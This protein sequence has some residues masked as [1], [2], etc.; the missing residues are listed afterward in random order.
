MEKNKSMSSKILLSMGLPIAC[1]FM[2]A[3]GIAL[4]V[5][6]HNFSSFDQFATVQNDLLLVF[7]IGLIVTIVIVALSIK[8]ISNRITKLVAVTDRLA[9]G[10]TDV[11][12][13]AA[14]RDQ[15]DD[16]G[17]GLAAIAEYI[18][19]QS[20]AA[21]KMAAGDLSGDIQPS[22]ENDL[23]AKSLASI[24]DSVK[25]IETTTAKAAQAAQ[26]GILEKNDGAKLSGDYSKVIGNVD[27]GLAAFAK[28]MDFYLAILDA[29]PYRITTIN[30]D[31]EIIFV[32]KTLGD[33]MKLTGS[34]EKRE[35][36]YGRQCSSCK[37]EMCNTENCGVRRL[38]EKG[39]TEYPFYF[40]E[41][42]YRMDTVHLKDKNGE[43][44]GFVDISHDTT[45]TMSI[46]AYT[47]NEIK[48]LA[49]NLL[50]LAD[51]NLDFD[52][53]IQ[54]AGEYTAEIC[55]E[56]KAIEK[57]LGQVSKSIGN[58]VE[59]AAVLSTA[60]I[61]GKL[62]TRADETK[63]N[64]A[65]KELISGMNRILEEIAGPTR[66]I[67]DVMNEMSAGNLHVLV[68]GAY[69]GEFHELKQ[70]VNTTAETLK[71]VVSKI[72][73]ITGQIADGNLNIES[74]EVWHN[75]FAD[76]SDALNKIVE[77]LNSLLGDIDDAARQVTAGSNQVSDASQALA[78]GSTEQASS[79]Q[80]LSAA[81]AEISDQTKNN[82]VNANQA[83]DLSTDVQDY[84]A[85][86][87]A[88]MAEMQNSMSEINKSSNDISK[89]IKVIDDIAFQTNIL[90]LNA[91]VEAARAGQHGKGFAVVAEEV[92]TLA[93]RSAEAAQETTGLIEGSIDTVKAG[94]KIADETAA[95]L[96]EIV[97]G[98]VKVTDLVGKIAVDSNEQASGIAQVNM[99]IE[100]V[101]QVVQNN[102]ATA[103]QSAAASE[104]LSG[105]AEMLK[106]MIG[107]F[108]LRK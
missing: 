28:Q 73:E 19:Y 15:L 21:K 69:K 9:A 10:D 77:T 27:Q 7:G 85:K 63:F 50:N 29:L 106:D 99:G 79:V 68:K 54:E 103:E 47:G 1:V 74:V 25:G 96:N 26:E 70:S 51:G 56:F 12:V 14:A 108:Q 35:D 16:L 92:R 42:Y 4:Y 107:Q 76:V 75:D 71:M 40:R 59:D 53:N 43:S 89:I 18:R 78:Q 33:L 34:A 32:N 39:L 102:S 3:A 80:E 46:N 105:Q 36:A 82:A 17:V 24:R 90:A 37:L 30:M 55:E 11:E 13:N 62:E 23:L 60:A 84:A 61:E 31:R 104:E 41:R 38:L 88:Q 81:V 97:E 83:K 65:W 48:R 93:A 57:S 2:V 52:L 64:G 87:N 94:T 20:L 5:V 91:A 101:A 66:E 22:S 58:L 6:N 8:G 86:G 100:Q 72:S 45:S 49:N 44:I 98:V 95:A 67:A